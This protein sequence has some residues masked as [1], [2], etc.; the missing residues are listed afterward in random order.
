MKTPFL[1]LIV[2]SALSAVVLA[3]LAMAQQLGTSTESP[4]GD[5]KACMDTMHSAGTTEE[6][7]KAMRE[8]MQSPKAPRLMNNMMEM[9]RRMGNGDPML[10]MTKMMKM[11]GGQGRMMGDRS[12][13]SR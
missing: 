2:V 7:A 10:G 13:G 6:G 4:S 8:F 12:G 1:S 11:T 9:A 3:P 5:A